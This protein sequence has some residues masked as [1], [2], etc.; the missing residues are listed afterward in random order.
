[1]INLLYC[2]DSNYNLQAFSSIISILDRTSIKINL[3]IIHKLEGSD[4][5]LPKSIKQHSNLN[6]CQVYKFD[7]KNTNFPNL[8]DV[9][10]SEATYYRIF[11][12]DYLPKNLEN[13]IYIDSDIICSRDPGPAFSNYIIKLNKSEYLLG[14]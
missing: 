11:L 5:F 9:H 13:I 2:F 10:V 12:D 14:A 4:S 8:E 6:I 3:Y 7:K 1:M